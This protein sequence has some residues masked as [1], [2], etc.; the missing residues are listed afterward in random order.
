MT[1]IKKPLFLFVAILLSVIAF[2][3]NAPDR[4]VGM[5]DEMRSNGRIY[6]VVAV[7]LT[8]FIGL[9]LYLVRI[10]RKISKWEKTEK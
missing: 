2:S 4:T 5:A 3:Q 1:T 8:I 10:D 6:V 9:I 7:I